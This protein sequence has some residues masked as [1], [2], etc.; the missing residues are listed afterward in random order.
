MKIKTV[1]ILGGHIQALGL[2]RQAHRLDVKVI[3]LLQDS[4]SVARF[5]R[6]VDSVVVCADMNH[7]KK[8]LHPFAGKHVLLF[9]TSDEY[10]EYLTDNYAELCQEYVL[11]IPK[12]DCVSIFADKRKT[13]QFAERLGIPHPKSWYPNDMDDVRKISATTT[14]PVV[15][16][17]AVMYSFHKTFGKKAFRCDTADELI[18]LCD[19]IRSKY[20]IDGLVIQD[21]LSGGAESLFS[22][23]AMVVKGEPIAW[24]M[25]N[26]IRQNPMDFGN[27][28]TFAV[29]CDIPE[30]ETSARNILKA[31]EYDGLAEVEFMYDDKE[32]VY[33]F[34]EINTRA[35]KW[36][37]ISMGLGFGF[38][39]E[40]IH[41]YNG[42]KGDFH[43]EFRKIAWVERLTDYT[44]A[45]KSIL[46]GRLKIG[47]VLRS[48]CQKKENAVWSWN[49]PLPALMYL[50]QSPILY[51]KR[52]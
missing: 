41:F 34:L 31:V 43:S 32:D 19:M 36:H 28:T 10:I 38:L 7:L 39:S 23:G 15:I 22:Y 44:V 8:V 3:L 30:M 11:G 17:P 47:N 50:L 18:S 14:F 24:V 48:Y 46:N 49:D 16:K 1:I 25:A 26:R 6:A 29:T 21:F 35:W 13:Y 20:P 40:M 42:E 45:L 27:S 37:S 51:F 5:S 33:K 52:H 2:A 12:P 4:F 9:P